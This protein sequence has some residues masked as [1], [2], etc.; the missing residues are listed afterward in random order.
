MFPESGHVVREVD[1]SMIREIVFG[2]YR[3]IY[4]LGSNRVKILAVFH[5]AR[6]LDETEF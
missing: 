1:S 5:G 2:Q 3:I 6:L 4:E